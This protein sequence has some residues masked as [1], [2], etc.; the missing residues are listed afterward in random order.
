MIGLWS[1][2]EKYREP[3]F[4]SLVFVILVWAAY[5]GLAGHTLVHSFPHGYY[6]SD[7]FQDDRW[8]QVIIDTGQYQYFPHFMTE[9]NDKV[10][11]WY[12][13]LLFHS[14]ALLS[15]TSGVQNYDVE[16]VLVAVI[17]A[18]GALLFYFFIRKIH[19]KIAILCVPLFVFLFLKTFRFGYSFGQWGALVGAALGVG[20][21]WS[22]F[23]MEKRGMEYV[24]GVFVA[25]AFSMHFPEMTFALGFILLHYLFTVYSRGFDVV[26]LKRLLCG[27]ALSVILSLSYIPRFVANFSIET[28]GSFLDLSK[29]ILEAGYPV[30]G[31][32]DFGLLSWMVGAGLVVGVVFVQK[33]ELWSPMLLSLFMLLIGFTNYLGGTLGSRAFHARLFWPVYLALFFGI[34]LYFI[35]GKFSFSTPLVLCVLSLLLS[36]G[37]SAA[38]YESA[39]SPGLLDPYHF[40]AYQWISANTAESA[41]VYFLYG[42][43]YSQVATL[44]Y[45]GRETYRLNHL[46]MQR[47]AQS[48]PTVKRGY[49]S[50]GGGTWMMVSQGLFDVTV[51][52]NFEDQLDICTMDYFVLDRGGGPRQLLEFN[53]AVANQLVSSN[54]TSVVFTNDVVAIL[55][56]N[57]VGKDCLVVGT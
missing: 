26:F 55:K 15:L 12:P 30:A 35:V 49:L 42:A 24:L 16:I 4:V 22:Y 9:G 20:I 6:A 2:I 50:V 46:E 31:L 34:S 11:A 45:T 57:A 36:V 38:S 48:P 53:L 8:A 3:A 18:L 17:V 44:W 23:W 39:P 13:P 27:A 43:P 52:P 7:A 32:S 14:S 5:A 25:A 33:K 51:L 10:V 37:I 19:E 29:P 56:N 40:E 47:V 1:T 21:I 28:G 41:K 54:T